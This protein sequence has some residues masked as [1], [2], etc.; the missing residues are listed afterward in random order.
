MVIEKGCA[1][2]IAFIRKIA[3]DVRK[4]TKRKKVLKKKIFFLSSDFNFEQK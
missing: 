3:T 4:E 1:N 2:L